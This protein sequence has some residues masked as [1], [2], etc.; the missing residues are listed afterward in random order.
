[1]TKCSLL[2]FYVK[3]N[4]FSSMESPN[5][6]ST[7][8]LLSE[9]TFAITQT[10][11]VV[12]LHILISHL[13]FAFSFGWFTDFAYLAL[14]VWSFRLKNSAV[15]HL[16]LAMMLFRRLGFIL[17]DFVSGFFAL[18]LF[19]V[20]TVT[21]VILRLLKR[22]DSIRVWLRRGVID[23]IVVFE[24][25]GISL[26]AA[27]ALVLWGYWT[28]DHIAGEMLKGLAGIPHLII[29]AAVI[30]GFALLNAFSEEALFRG[31]FQQAALSAKWSEY[32]AIVLQA[33][34]FAAFHVVAGFPN[35]KLGYAMTFIYAV[36]LGFLRKQ[37]KGLLAPYLTHVTADLVIAYFLYFNAI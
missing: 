11:A 36:A 6:E 4:K 32:T 10:Q 37:T 13:S 29:I 7:K 22:A 35:G 20:L 27:L 12:L 34:P 8:G 5:I 25:I 2:D 19:I 24:M 3:L 30:P 9:R 28:D 18:Y 16:S 17:P 1:M 15:I 14:T 33:M 26:T 23:R 31:V 21:W